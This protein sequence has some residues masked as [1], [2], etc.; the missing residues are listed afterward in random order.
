MVKYETFSVSEEHE[1]SIELNLPV[2]CQSQL[3][4]RKGMQLACEGSPAQKPS[5][6]YT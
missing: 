4:G 2:I 3:E 1:K 5:R 6:R